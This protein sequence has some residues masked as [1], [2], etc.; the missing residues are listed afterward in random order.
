MSSDEMRRLKVSD[1]VLWVEDKAV[2]MVVEL[3]PMGI[4]IDWDDGFTGQQLSF[5]NA[6][7]IARFT[8]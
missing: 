8:L 7:R 5:V 4:T 6:D 3:L 2:G 1:R